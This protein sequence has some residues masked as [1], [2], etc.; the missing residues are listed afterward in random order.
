MRLLFMGT[1]QFA[2]P[3][4]EL[5][6]QHTQVVGVVTQPDK[7]TGRGQRLTPP[8]VKVAAQRLGLPVFQPLKLREP[9]VL[10][11][12]EALKPEIVVVAAYAKL[13]P[14]RFLEMPPLGCV[15]LHPSLLP[16]HRGA[17]PIQAAIMAGDHKTGVTTFQMEEGYDTG[18]I[19][20]QEE[21][22][23]G[24]EET[25]TELSERLAQLGAP[26]LWRTVQGLAQGT[27]VPRPQEGEFNYTKPFGREDLLFN[28]SR[29]AQELVD[30]V[31]ALYAEPQASAQAG[32]KVLKVGRLRLAPEWDER[33]QSAQP[34]EVLGSIK[35]RGYVIASGRGAVL[36]D[37]VK[38]A[39]KGWM[40]GSAY[41][42]GHPLA[43]GV[44]LG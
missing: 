36:L 17:I 2:V 27:I 21:T 6:A 24:P 39:G 22:D 34:G 12:L 38:P 44:L 19:L 20:L 29:P 8:P 7:P 11:E 16:R 32:D 28:W 4:L 9:Q 25:G 5:L 23:L 18:A 14:K 42:A 40:E 35:G 30:W 3:S 10:E 33:A 15:N 26:L 41:L 43:V 31:R 37:L 13:L 1:P